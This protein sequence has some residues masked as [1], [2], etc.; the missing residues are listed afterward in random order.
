M[1]NTFLNVSARLCRRGNPG[2]HNRP[3][4]FNPQCSIWLN[5]IHN[6]LKNQPEKMGVIYDLYKFAFDWKSE[7][8]GKNHGKN[9]SLSIPPPSP[10][11]RMTEGLNKVIAW[12]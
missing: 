4:I 10:T 9:F 1:P 12:R 5:F 8:S 2:N 11:K 3:Q 7:L 6:F